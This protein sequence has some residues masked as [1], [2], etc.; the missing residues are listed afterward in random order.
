MLRRPH[1][2]TGLSAGGDGLDD[3][4]MNAV[5][6]APHVDQWRDDLGYRLYAGDPTVACKLDGVRA[7]ADIAEQ[8]EQRPRRCAARWIERVE[9]EADLGWHVPRGLCVALAAETIVKGDGRR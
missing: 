2:A 8:L 1:R 7:L 4:R 3:Q 9:A 6:V 5:V